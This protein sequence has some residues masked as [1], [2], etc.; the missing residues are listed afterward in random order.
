MQGYLAPELK[1]GI[2]SA[3]LE[4]KDAEILELFRVERIDPTDDADYDVLRDMATI[5]ELDLAKVN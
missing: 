2:R 4:L 3:F 1:E 5:L